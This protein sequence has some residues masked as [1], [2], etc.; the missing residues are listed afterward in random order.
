MH[1]H[2]ALYI[3]WWFVHDADLCVPLAVRIAVA[4][5]YLPLYLL[6]SGVYEPPT[7]WHADTFQL[8]TAVK[9]Q[10]VEPWALALTQRRKWICHA[11]KCVPAWQRVIWVLNIACWQ[12]W[13]IIVWIAVGL[14]L[15]SAFVNKVAGCICHA[16]CVRFK[17]CFVMSTLGLQEL[18]HNY[19][20]TLHTHYQAFLL[21]SFNILFYICQW[22]ALLVPTAGLPV[23]RQVWMLFGS[24]A[25][26]TVYKCPEV[27]CSGTS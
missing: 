5:A 23:Y 13:F 17:L 4:Q 22:E 25:L 11:L 9:R 6:Q 3:S 12:P 21:A 20:N 14:G 7:F 16:S 10:K 15:V 27:S 19:H 24:R 26:L 8:E 18:V 1:S 2:H